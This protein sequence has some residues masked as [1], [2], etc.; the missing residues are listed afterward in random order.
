MIISADSSPCSRFLNC[1]Q[2][3]FEI[4]KSCDYK[5]NILYRTLHSP[6]FWTA[7]LG[8]ALVTF[9]AIVLTGI[10]TIPISIFAPV[11]GCGLVALG[12]VI[13]K[14]V[15]QIWYEASLLKVL[16]SSFIGF[17]PW[18]QKITSKVIL[19]G[20]PLK[21]YRDHKIL[22]KLK[23]GAV[24]SLVNDVEK[25]PS[26]LSIPVQKKK[27]KSM[28]IDYLSLGV[29]DITAPK[30]KQIST[31]VEFI[32]KKEKKGIRTYVH[33]KAGVGRSATIVTCYLL[34][35]HPEKFQHC[36]GKTQVE[37]AI[38]YV[39]K[40]RPSTHM[41]TSQIKQIHSFAKKFKLEN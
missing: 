20:I 31:A 32:N 3:E 39:T 12:F 18:Q 2:A 28:N 36:K 29:V 41:S 40:K 33:C 35:Y 21:N 15:E 6:L 26:I 13:C 19:G 23:I 24:V 25:E 5:Q 10:L 38:A 34:K 22:Q 9:S 8:T 37:K 14:N 17:H 4:Q 7:S 27:W 30:K 16:F 11:V 1:I